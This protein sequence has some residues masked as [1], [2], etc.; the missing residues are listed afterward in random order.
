MKRFTETAKWADPW[1][2]KLPHTLKIGYLYLLDNVDNAGVIDLDKDLADFQIGFSVDWSELESALGERVRVL[3]CGKWYLTR[4]VRFQYG[5]LSTDSKPH[6][7]VTKLLFAHGV[8]E[9]SVTTDTPPEGYPKGIDTPKDKDKG[10]DKETDKE[11]VAK[12]DDFPEVVPGPLNTP[13]F[14]AA[15]LDWLAYRRERK[16]A[17]WKPITVR[18]TL[19]ELAGLGEP[20]AI[21]SIRKSIA[22]GWQGLFEPKTT[23]TAGRASS[24]PDPLRGPSGPNG[25]LYKMF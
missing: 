25:D 6:Q 15:W 8:F 2:R 24:A 16:L 14:R 1:F 21:E 9:K 5:E 10:S 11:R 18:A 7:Q 13:A 4:F 12:S 23:L 3:S 20:A 19:I 17:I 22:N